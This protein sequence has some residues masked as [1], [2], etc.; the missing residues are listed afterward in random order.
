MNKKTLALHVAYIG[1]AVAV[2][3]AA[4]AV[5]AIRK[6]GVVAT[7]PVVEKRTPIDKVRVKTAERK[8]GLEDPN[9]ATATTAAVGIVCGR[10]KATADRYE[11]RN[12]ALRSIARRRDLEKDDV[13]ALL[14]Y[15][16][17]ADNAM[18]VERVAALKNDVMNLLRN[19]ESPVEGLAETLIVMIEERP[20]AGF[21]R[22]GRA[23]VPPPAADGD[24]TPSLPGNTIHPSAVIDYCIQH[25]GAMV[26][27]L[28]DTARVGV[29]GVLVRAARD[30]AKSYAGTALYSLAEDK[31][32]TPVQEGEL[33]R[34]TLALCKPG[35]NNVARI[36]AIQLAGQRGYAEALP[37]L[38]D[39]LSGEKRDAVLDTVCIGSIGLLGNAD[40]IALIERFK[41]DTR[42]SAAVEAA[43][44]RIKG[45][46]DIGTPTAG[47]EVS[48]ML[49]PLL[50]AVQ[51]HEIRSDSFGGL[52]AVPPD[53]ENI[54]GGNNRGFATRS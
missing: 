22:S 54:V 41:G 20:V 31:R 10:D 29:R 52:G 39:T 18:R 23:G 28:D 42:R 19:Q 24:G 45:R 3:M 46:E 15:L 14:A 38:R 35:I 49:R 37:V 30:K 11:A 32:A 40:D 4:A 16:R 2:L 53:K 27:E 36:A 17:K 8:S 25:L 43:I 7:K 44:K 33:K 34:L 50:R 48:L 47:K 26:N 9:G 5:V 1:T 51:P 12:D 21:G 6:N 13:A